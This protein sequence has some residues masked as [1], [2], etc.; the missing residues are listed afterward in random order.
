MKRLSN[1]INEANDIR[2]YS[3]AILIYDNQVLLLR[4]SE[5]D[6][7]YKGYWGFPGGK[8]KTNED[9]KK[10]VIREV[11]EETGID[12]TV[13]E[14]TKMKNVD[15]MHYN[16]QNSVPEGETEYWLVELESSPEIKLSTEH[17]SYKWVDDNILMAKGM[18]LIP[19]VYEI[20]QKYYNEYY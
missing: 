12:L 14:Q 16:K 13:N 8:I 9:S 7:P 1:Y 11:K 19:G 17:V 5:K 2:H 6:P 20:I 3:D 18:K 15:K 10:A 4:R